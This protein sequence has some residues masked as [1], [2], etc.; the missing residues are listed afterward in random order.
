MCMY[1]I[2]LNDALLSETRRS[3]GSDAA[4]KTW[5]QQQVEALLISYNTNQKTTRQ[6]ARIAIGKM[7]RQS[8]GNGNA[9]LSLD[10]I[11]AEIYETRKARKNIAV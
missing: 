3:F 11:N 8:E 7:R 1:N 6:R 2:P 10:E 9:R 5:L 4:M